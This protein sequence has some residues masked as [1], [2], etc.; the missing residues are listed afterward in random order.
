MATCQHYRWAVVVDVEGGTSRQK[1]IIEFP[2]IIIDIANCCEKGRFHR[3]IRP[4]ELL[5]QSQQQG[6]LVNRSSNAVSFPS[7]MQAFFRF[8]EDV[9]VDH[10]EAVL[11][12]CGDFD[13]NA[14]HHN[15][16][17]H[18]IKTHPF[19]TRWMNLKDAVLNSEHARD[20]SL[21]LRALVS[22]IDGMNRL[23]RYMDM[24]DIF[25]AENIKF[26][27]IG[28]HDTTKIARILLQCILR[29]GQV[30]GE[31]AQ[32]VGDTMEHLSGLHLKQFRMSGPEAQELDAV[33]E[34]IQCACAS[35]PLESNDFDVNTR[36]KLTELAAKGQLEATLGA[37]ERYAQ[38]K[39]RQDVK[40]WAGWVHS[41]V[42][43]FS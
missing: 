24:H 8:L 30:V 29:K 14:L 3:W 19:F 37:L 23:A 28:M 27:H 9:N 12:C 31:T 38:M 26:H 43:K 34:A 10:S 1:E 25:D 21:D 42:K 32:R 33:E 20:S 13:A 4:E 35:S 15:Y 17:I 11:V 22:Q 2:A 5:K 7:A 16:K 36:R 6:W 41:L 40:N 18:H 39:E